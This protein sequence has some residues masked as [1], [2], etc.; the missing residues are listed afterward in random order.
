[1]VFVGIGAVLF[2]ILTLLTLRATYRHHRVIGLL[3][4]TPVSTVADLVQASPPA[5]L[6]NLNHVAVRGHVVAGEETRLTAPI[7]GRS[8]VAFEFAVFLDESDE[9]PATYFIKDAKFV[10]WAVNDGTGIARVVPPTHPRDLKTHSGHYESWPGTEASTH[11]VKLS[12]FKKVI[13]QYGKEDFP[14]WAWQE[15]ASRASRTTW[16]FP[17]QPSSARLRYQDF[18]WTERILREYGNEMLLVGPCTVH[19]GSVRFQHTDSRFWFGSTEVALLQE[20]SAVKRCLSWTL[21]CLTLS[22]GSAYFYFT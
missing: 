5:Y 18:Q 12:D 16:I 21:F 7:T 19:E 4:E 1:M 9:D 17:P 13:S 3:R 20:R 10:P 22:V 11:Q 6:S 14:S 8:C 15:K 2:L